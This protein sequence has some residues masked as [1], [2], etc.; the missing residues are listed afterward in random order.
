MSMLWY[1]LKQSKRWITLWIAAALAFFTICISSVVIWNKAANPNSDL[2]GDHGKPKIGLALYATG[3]FQLFECI[4]NGDSCPKF[5]SAKESM[6]GAATE[7]T[8][9]PLAGPRSPGQSNPDGTRTVTLTD[10]TDSQWQKVG[11]SVM[12]DGTLS[13]ESVLPEK[14]D[15]ADSEARFTVPATHGNPS[16]QG[17]VAFTYSG[18]P[19][20]PD[21]VQVLSVTYPGSG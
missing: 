14:M 4:S 17:V 9:T 6:S 1:D 18:E 2:V 11:Q 15:V 19:E 12:R 21:D 13:V 16:G 8:Y 10:L 5:D 3:T 7:F 20:A